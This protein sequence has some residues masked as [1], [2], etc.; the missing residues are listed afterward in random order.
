MR[1]LFLSLLLAACAFT[2]MAQTLDAY[3]GRTPVL[4]QSAPERDKGLRI[5]LA[6]VLAR[7]SGDT[8]LAATGRTSPILARAGSL[9]RSVSYESNAQGSLVLVADFDPAAVE[10]ALQQAGLPVW[11]AL[12]SHVEEV[13]MTV[14]AVDSAQD[15]ARTMAALKRVPGIKS[16]FVSGSE[17]E[18]LRL[19][20]RVEG[21]AG[22]LAG[23]LSVGGV[24][25]P[26]ASED[27]SLAYA[28]A[29]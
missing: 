21:G 24:L 13:A 28:L 5:A 20:L 3:Q 10:S 12:A 4:D 18:S 19:Q 14:S 7:V 1:P 15:Y 23:A 11:G 29:R 16:L 22:R 27:G 8:R 9:L 25:R 2:A 17:G 26:Q 6:Q